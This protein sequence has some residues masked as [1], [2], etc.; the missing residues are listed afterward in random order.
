MLVHEVM[1]TGLVTVMKTDTVQSVVMKMMKHHWMPFRSLRGGHWN[2]DVARGLVA[3]FKSVGLILSPV[4]K[5]MIL[6]A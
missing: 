4:R 6:E 5:Q 3:A 2:D 1:L